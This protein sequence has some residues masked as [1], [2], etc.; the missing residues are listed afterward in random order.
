[1]FKVKSTLVIAFLFIT[2]TAT[3]WTAGKFTT[4]YPSQFEHE[5]I[6]HEVKQN[7]LIINATAYWLMDNVVVHTLNSQFGS[8]HD[9]QKNMDIAFSLD[10]EKAISEIWILPE[11]T[12]EL[13]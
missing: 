7:K 10:D 6:L 9:L 2:L 4:Y 5:G 8:L 1:M 3:C 13:D 12:V 11:G